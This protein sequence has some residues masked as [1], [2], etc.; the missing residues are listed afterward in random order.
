VGN[1]GGIGEFY[2]DVLQL[3]FLRSL[4][5]MLNVQV[6]YAGKIQVAAGK[7]CRL[8]YPH[9][10]KAMQAL[11]RFGKTP[12]AGL[13]V[14]PTGGGKTLTAV[15]WLLRNYI[16]QGKK[17][18]WVAH[19]HELLNQAL[20]TLKS[21]AYRELLP[22]REDFRYR[23]ISGNDKHDRPINI[24]PADDIIIAS[25][26]SL[27]S[28]IEHLIHNWVQHTDDILVV[29]DEA[30]HATAKTYRKLI[31][32]IKVNLE[33]RNQLG[34]FQM[35][36][37]T[38]T[39]FRTDDGEQGL[40]KQVFPDDIVFTEHLRNLISCGILSEPV[41]EA[42]ATKQN[43]KRELTPRDIKKIENFDQ[44]PPH[45]A[46]KIAESN[47][48]N[49]QIVSQ[50][51][52]NR[53]QYCPVLLFAIDVDHAIA[54]NGLFQAKGVKSD[55]V[56]SSIVD[57][58]T[59]ARTSIKDN[60]EKIQRF[61]N[62]E[63]EVLINVE[64]LTEG[65][66]LPN[67]QT[68]FLTR[69]TTSTILMTQMIGRG[70]RGQKAG[71][72]EKA[73]VVSFIDDWEDK[74]NWVNPEQLHL[75]EGV[76]FDDDNRRSSQTV[77]R[78][79]AIDKIEEFA[80]MM[81]E[82]IDTR[83]LEQ[84]EFLQRIPVGIYRFS[85][86]EATGEDET[87]EPRTGYYQVLLYSDTAEAYDCLIHDF[88][89]LLRPLNI[90][91]RETLTEQELAYLLQ[92]VKQDYF[93]NASQLMGY[94]DEDVQNLLRFYAQKQ[95]KPDFLAFPDR[96]KCN[97]AAFAQDIYDQSL[98]GKAK[99]EY[100]DA[101]WENPTAFWQVIFANDRLSFRKNLEIEIQK[102]EGFYGEVPAPPIVIPDDVPLEKFSLE[103]IRQ[104]HPDQYQRIKDQLFQ[105]ATDNHGFITCALSG[106]KGT[107]RRLFQIDHRL[108]MSEGGLTR[109]DNLQVLSKQAHREKTTDENRQRLL[110]SLD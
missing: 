59:G 15:H 14:L 83:T 40:L 34:G 45:I 81:D 90:G 73:Y 99:A 101:H 50:Y 19:R 42:L 13:L 36:G 67:V 66:D 107:T 79:I 11:D 61:R 77:T 41:F 21:S 91:D 65:T 110:L 80:R 47:I 92:V 46:K 25:K 71:G 53:E 51:L 43:F 3:S 26:D 72:T 17:V 56:V 20:E 105:Q 6:D 55:Y 7:N 29:I 48:R 69:P 8:L 108:P 97:L 23:I 58:H 37:L 44:L 87:A 1:T 86:L 109:L 103:Q 16:D 12:S 35:L 88:E 94:R 49:N 33:Q 82:S 24:K 54:L 75:R 100:I 4:P 52:K 10:T 74:I 98:G 22:Q 68:V 9:Q 31:D 70:L 104:Y 96:Q 95:A 84:V 28:G 38:A 27:N 64:I 85:I 78:L 89:L 106:F 32:R 39:P 76:E 2:A 5:M 63:L 57:A 60:P 18:L 30:H 102:L 93:P 62:G